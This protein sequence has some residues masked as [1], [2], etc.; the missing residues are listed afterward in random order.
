MKVILRTLSSACVAEWHYSSLKALH[1]NNNIYITLL[2]FS[3]TED[4]SDKFIPNSGE[5]VQLQNSLIYFFLFLR[6]Q[7][8]EWMK[9]FYN[10]NLDP[11]TRKSYA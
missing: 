4:T 9:E 5:N 10:L 8:N 1:A 3:S 7:V 2:Y 6:A 11:E